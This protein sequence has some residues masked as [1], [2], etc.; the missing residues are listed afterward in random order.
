[1][2]ELTIDKT[3]AGALFGVATEVKKEEL[4]RGE[5]TEVLEV[6]EQE[7]DFGTFYN[8]PT[9]SV[10]DKKDI[11][12]KVFEGRISQELLNFLCILAD[13]GRTRHYPKIVKSYERMCNAKD[14]FASGVVYSVR[15]L[16]EDRVAK[17]EEETSNLIQ[18]NVKLVNETDPALIGGIKILVNGKIIDASLRRRLSDM[19]NALDI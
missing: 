2:A 9:I 17:L 6:F 5:L 11:L 19:G 8:N 7:P 14:G 15:P 12:N 13:K 4:I 10:A 3:Y 18:E 16:T 1:M